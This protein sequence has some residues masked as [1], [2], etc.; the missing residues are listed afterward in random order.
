MKFRKLPQLLDAVH[1]L[2]ENKGIYFA[3]CGSSA[4]KVKRGYANLLG[5]R[6]V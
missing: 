2:I 3:L 4:R 6:G 1:W 5:G